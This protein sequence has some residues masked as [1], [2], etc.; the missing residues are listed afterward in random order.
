MTEIVK[1]RYE[2]WLAERDDALQTFGGVGLKVD[3]AGR[4]IAM[5]IHLTDAMYQLAMAIDGLVAY[6]KGLEND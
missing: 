3:S 6:R 1:Q 5:Y 2:K 4:P